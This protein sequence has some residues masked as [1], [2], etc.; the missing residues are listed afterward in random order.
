LTFNET[1]ASQF[2]EKS[3]V[4]RRIARKR[5]QA[6]KDDSYVPLAAREQRGAM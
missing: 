1:A 2:V 5:Q 6:T 4:Y 3:Q